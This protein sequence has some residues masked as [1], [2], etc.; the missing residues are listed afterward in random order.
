MLAWLLLLLPSFIVGVLC[1]LYINKQW[2]L[3][4]AAALPWFGLLA[5][6]IYTEYFTPN[7]NLDASMWPIA[8]LVGGT[9]AAI[10]GACGFILTK[11][12]KRE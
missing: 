4:I 6:L 2:G 1:G 7:E 5:A 10:A 12:L 3:W 9:V 11:K 8:Q